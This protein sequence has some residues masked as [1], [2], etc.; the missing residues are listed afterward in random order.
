MKIKGK[1]IESQYEI[2][3]LISEGVNPLEY[4]EEDY[5]IDLVTKAVAHAESSE[6]PYFDDMAETLLKSIVYYLYAKDSETKS[7]KRCKEIL[8]EVMNSSDRRAEMINILGDNE[9]AKVLYKAI[10][11]ASD[12]TYNS[13][14]DTLNE[15]LEKIIK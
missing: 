9:S 3:Q 5:D 4:M 1:M 15:K 12:R 2:L 11:I 14:F 10:E 6:D 7:L 13:I 8:D